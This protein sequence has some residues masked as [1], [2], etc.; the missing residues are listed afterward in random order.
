MKKRTAALCALLTFV[1]SVSIGCSGNRDLVILDDLDKEITTIT[2]FGYKYEPENVTVIEEILSEF[3]AENPD[4]RISYES[5]KGNGY[6]D[7][8]RKRMASGKGNDVFLANHDV[9]LELE[10]Q[11][12]VADLSGLSAIGNY[13]P[14]M[15]SQMEEGKI[16]WVPTTVSVFGLYCNLDLLK[17]HGREVPGNLGE[18][19]AVCDYFVGEGITPIIA[20]ND[21]SLKTLAIGRGFY[22]IYQENRQAEVFRQ[23]NSGEMELSSYLRSGFSLGEAFI[24]KGYIDGE[25]ALGTEK[26]SEDLQEFIK[27]ES[28]FMLT[29]AWAAGRVKAMEPDFEFE[30]A[31]LPALEDG[32]L[33][34][35]N[36]DTKLCVNAH[37]PHLEAAMKFVEYFTKEENIQK[38]ADQQSSFSPLQGGNPSSV[39]EVRPLISDY[40]GGRTVIGTDT[41]LRLP[42]WNLTAEASEKLLAGEPLD[43]VMERLDQQAEE[44]RL[45]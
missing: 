11:G 28:P 13:T 19:E 34:V 35:I 8:L 44:D 32:T 33:L 40:A 22:S 20:N 24:H 23:L 10:Q 5:I 15:R 36:P 3:M 38:F 1:L 27:G 29:G 17:E 12:K 31:P 4:I 2:F 9:L 25:K 41:L 43:M 42:I 18:W 14:Q 37:S 21:T 7:A 6:H 30:V 16:Y 45:R 26:T 39:K